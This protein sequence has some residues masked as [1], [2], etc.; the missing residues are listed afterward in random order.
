MQIPTTQTIGLWIGA[1]YVI[2]SGANA[3]LATLASQFPN[4]AWLH[5]L[6]S[7]VSIITVDWQSISGQVKRVKTAVDAGDKDDTIKPP[8]VP[9]ASP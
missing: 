4:S 9:P 2:L 5:K 1:S 6:S 3:V 7:T 8:P